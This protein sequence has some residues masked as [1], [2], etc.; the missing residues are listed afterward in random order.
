MKNS[1]ADLLPGHRPYNWR[2][3]RTLSLPSRAHIGG[4]LVAFAIASAGAVHATPLEELRKAQVSELEFGSFRLEVGLAGIKDW[5]YPIE[6]ASVTP[7]VNPD[8][9]DIVIAVGKDRAAPFRTTC[10]RTLER[11]RE[12][13]YVGVDG[14]APMGRSH[15]SFYFRGR[16][17]GH[18]REAALRA[19]DDSARIRVDVVGQGS[20]EAA[21]L[22]A[23]VR[24]TPLPPK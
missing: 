18:T 16:W 22:N 5:P 17:R 20:C 21:L 13:L 24:F 7:R 11:V 4:A 8:Q 3:A 23:P 15:L 10:T 2:M 12:F 6:G 19:L 14:A 1:E 9:L